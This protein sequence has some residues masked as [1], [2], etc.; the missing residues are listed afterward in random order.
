MTAIEFVLQP[1]PFFHSIN[2][3]FIT[4][5]SVISALLISSCLWNLITCS[6]V[7]KLCMSR[8]LKNKF[9]TTIEVI[10]WNA[11]VD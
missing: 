10:S 4:N 8:Y 2:E 6:L 9:E 5:I 7:L 1:Q 11:L 3:T